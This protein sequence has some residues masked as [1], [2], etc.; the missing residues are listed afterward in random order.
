MAKCHLSL[1]GIVYV[2]FTFYGNFD[3]ELQKLNT[4]QG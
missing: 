2:C 3:V 1:R 4:V